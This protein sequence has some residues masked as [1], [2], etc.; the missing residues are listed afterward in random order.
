VACHG[1]DGAL[2]IFANGFGPGMLSNTQP[3][4]RYDIVGFRDGASG[5][6]EIWRHKIGVTG[7]DERDPARDPRITAAPAVDPATGTLLATTRTALMVFID[8]P[9]KSGEVAPDLILEPL[10]LLTPEIRA[11]ATRAE[12]SSP[13]TLSR[14]G[15]GGAFY[16]YVGLAVFVSWHRR[17]FA[18]TTCL[19]VEPGATPRVTPVWTASNALDASGNAAPAARSFAQPALFRTMGADGRPQTGLVMSTMRDGVAIYR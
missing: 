19:R 14:K 1:A 12:L 6:T 17:A 5:L 7:E 16:A 13:I 4:G 15:Q 3:Q 2:S 18:F 10:R 8:A 11:E 9:A